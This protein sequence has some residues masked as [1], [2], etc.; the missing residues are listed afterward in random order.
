VFDSSTELLGV[1]KQRA[2]Q[3]AD[4]PGFPAPV[5]RTDGAGCGAGVR[6]LHG[7]GFGEPRSRGAGARPL[8]ILDATTGWEC[9]RRG[10][11]EEVVDEAVPE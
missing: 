5:E 4:E 10:S 8:A 3:L 9:A 7:R 6:S 11:S 1:T 2:H